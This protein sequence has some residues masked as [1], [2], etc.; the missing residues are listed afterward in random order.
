[1]AERVKTQLR[2]VRDRVLIVILGGHLA[3]QLF[4]TCKTSMCW[5]PKNDSSF[6]HI[7]D[8]SNRGQAGTDIKDYVERQVFILISWH[9]LIA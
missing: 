3:M 6:N 8:L 7:I 1:M 4:Y 5:Y 2:R 9:I